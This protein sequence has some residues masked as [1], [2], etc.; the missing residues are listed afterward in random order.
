MIQAGDDGSAVGETAADPVTVYGLE[1]LQ[2]LVDGFP[3]QL[4]KLNAEVA[5]TGRL[6]IAPPRSAPRGT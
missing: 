4:E 6:P 3:E 5:K 2:K 1:G